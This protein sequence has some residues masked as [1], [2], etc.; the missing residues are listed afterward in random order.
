M[1][2]HMRASALALGLELKF[3]DQYLVD[4]TIAAS[5]DAS[6]GE[7]NPSATVALSTIA[8]GDGESNRD[9]RNCVLKSV[10]VE[11]TISVDPQV[12][13]TVQHTAPV[14]FLALV[15]DK[16]TN[17][18]LLN[19]E[20]VFT[21]PSGSAKTMSKPLRNL[22]Y[23]K[24]FQVLKTKTITLRQNISTYDGTNLETGGFH[25]PFKLAASLPDIKCNYSSTSADIANS[26]D[27]SLHI[28]AFTTENSMVPKLN[29]V[30]RVRFVG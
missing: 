26:V 8:Q 13:Q 19:S 15:W 28:I 10:F 5:T 14:V 17:G 6:G 12:D 9:G 11:G 20:D 24:R 16:Q 27:N 21:N 29:Y 22:K 7:A 2:P 23:T 4:H 18:A 3:Y 30:S 1:A 25:T